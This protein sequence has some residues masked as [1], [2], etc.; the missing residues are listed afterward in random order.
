MSLRIRGGLVLTPEGFRPGEIGIRGDRL[1]PPNSL[2]S[3]EILEA[4]GLY[5][6]PGLIDTHLHG[7]LAHD[8]MD[9]TEEA[10]EGI[11]RQLLCHGVTSWVPTTVACPPLELDKVLSQIDRH[12]GQGARIL[13]AHLESSVISPNYR[14]AQPDAL[15]SPDDPGFREVVGRWKNLIR[16]VTLAPELP[17]AMPLIRHLVEWGIRPSCGHSNASFEQVSEAIEAGLGRITHLFNAQRPFHHREPGVA[18]AGLAF[19]NLFAEI[20][21]DGVHVH[22]AAVKIAYRCKGEKLVLVSDA[23]RGT[24]LEPGTYSLGGQTTLIDGQVARLESGAI[25]GSITLLDRAVKNLQQWAGITLEQA[26][27]AATK[28]PALSLGREDLGELM[29]GSL[30]DVA[31]FDSDFRCRTAIVGGQIRFQN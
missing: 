26:L 30:A 10:L 19:E 1:V 29:L 22:P 20:V 12:Q 24:D 2:E 28:A 16:V 3:P 8:T 7:V 5:V 13:G 21:S 11:S 6:C 18:G 27:F 15:L 14:G 4:D 23:L 17:G 9:G 25:A 31:L